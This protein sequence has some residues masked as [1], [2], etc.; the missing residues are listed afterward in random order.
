MRLGCN[1][2][3]ENRCKM[4]DEMGCIKFGEARLQ[5]YMR[6]ACKAYER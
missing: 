5:G 4:L 2:L 3:D 6:H 1:G